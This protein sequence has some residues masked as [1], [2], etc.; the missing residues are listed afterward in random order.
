MIRKFCLILLVLLF[1]QVS[2]AQED[3]LN[4]PT[5]LYVLTNGGQVQQFGMGMA[6]LSVVT[7]EDEFILDFG[8]A[9]DGNWMAYR[10]EAGLRLFNIYQPDDPPVELAGAEAGIPPVRGEGDTI[11]WSPNG[12]AI[13]TTT[14][15]GAR[16]YFPAA[17]TAIDLR[18]GQFTQVIWSPNGSYL[19]AE[20]DQ[21]IWWV[22]RREANNLVLTSAIP[23]AVGVA[24]GGVS[25]L[26]FAPPDGGL[27]LM[28]L[29][30]AN[31][32]TT[33][34]DNTWTY[35]L[36]Y[37]LGDGTIAVYGRQKDDELI[38]E[39]SGRLIGLTPDTRD[40]VGL[41][42]VAVELNGLQWAPGGQLMV[43][44]RGGVMAAVIPATGQGLALPVSDAVAYSWGP[45]PLEQVFS[46]QTPAN[47]FFLSQDAFGIQQ[48]WWLPRDGSEA[49]ALTEAE[50]DVTLYA[51]SPDQR[52]VAYVSGGQL[53]IQ[54]MNGA[55]ADSLLDLGGAGVGDLTFSPEGTRIAYT[56]EP[57]DS[58]PA[59]GIW[60]IAL[61]GGDGQ[62]VLA[63]GDAEYRQP[64]F[65]PNVNALL[66]QSVSVGSTDYI[67]LDLTSQEQI[68][69]GSFERALWLPDGRILGYGS[70]AVTEA[71]PQEQTITIFNPADSTRVELASLVFP[72]HIESARVIDATRVRLVL[73]SYA[74]GPQ[75]LTVVDLD[76]TNGAI[77]PA[78]DGGFMFAPT[79]STEG[80]M[81]G[82]QTRPDG[83][84]T[85]RDLTT[86]RQV[87]LIN[88]PNAS[89][90]QWGSG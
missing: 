14:A 8:I 33:L 22:Y 85:F 18:E 31:A 68:T 21:N 46:L 76:T 87:I 73:S 58:T 88:P 44:F 5:E 61:S 9:P 17:N 10:T 37:L 19:A 45:T 62:L 43:A 57:T 53:W 82:G 75:A 71:P 1:A 64:Q 49:E 26:I 65:A 7:P 80:T 11:A 24:W 54:P 42:D 16:I 6:G 20:A 2:L 28:D 78:G 56:T 41:G 50:A 59:A 79:V 60:I 70:S 84:L 72:A 13:A 38:P 30:A 4:L 48:V 34:L 47:G 90:F 86:G 3:G 15:Y 12:D 63:N 66:A 55:G 36:P 67:V 69:V 83:T 23:S 25:Q 40:V 35:S 51:I 89:R 29:S 27:F 52:T 77:T 74:D 81:L 39:G 32:Q